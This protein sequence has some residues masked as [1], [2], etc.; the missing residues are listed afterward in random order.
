[1]QS[2]TCAPD[3]RKRSTKKK[4]APQAKGSP[5]GESNEGPG[6]RAEY[7]HDS[8]LLIQGC[9]EH[10]ALHESNSR[11]P[12]NY[13]GEFG[14]FDSGQVFPAKKELVPKTI[15]ISQHLELL[16]DNSMKGWSD[17]RACNMIF[18]QHPNPGVDRIDVA[19]GL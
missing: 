9:D 3:R 10:V 11:V 4:A 12:V 17:A 5:R 14:R 7:H 19:I 18:G 13:I 1:M 6:S 15:S 8:E 16:A 2:S